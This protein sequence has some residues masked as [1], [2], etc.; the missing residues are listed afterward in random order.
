V[1]AVPALGDDLG[2]RRLD[3]RK[4][5]G[6]LYDLFYLFFNFLRLNTP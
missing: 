4:H 3:G 5:P 2:L 1:N 6:L